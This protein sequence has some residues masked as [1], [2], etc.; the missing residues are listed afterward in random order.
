MRADTS[1]LLGRSGHSDV[2]SISPAELAL[3]ER[4]KMHGGACSV[5]T[6][7]VA[8]AR[9]LVALKLGELLTDG[10]DLEVGRMWKFTLSE[11]VVVVSRGRR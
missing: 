9:V 1:P 4:A 7:Q 2:I 11:D 5:T 3:V 10:E 6:K 8:A